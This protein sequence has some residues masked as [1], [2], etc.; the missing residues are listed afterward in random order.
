MKGNRSPRKSSHVLSREEPKIGNKKEIL[1]KR[2][3]MRPTN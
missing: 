3:R 1:E 2:K